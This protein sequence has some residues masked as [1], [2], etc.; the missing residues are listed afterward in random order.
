MA[1]PTDPHRRD[2]HN[3]EHV[4]AARSLAA[5]LRAARTLKTITFVAGLQQRAMVAPFVLEGAM[6]ELMF[7]I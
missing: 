1:G 6:N 7:L 2:L 4:A 3:H 5:R